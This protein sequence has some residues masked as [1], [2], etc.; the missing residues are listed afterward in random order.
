VCVTV[1]GRHTTTHYPIPTKLTDPVVP[2]PGRPR[3]ARRQRRVVGGDRLDVAP[4]RG[5][6]LVL[7]RGLLWLHRRGAARALC[8]RGEGGRAGRGRQARDTE[9]GGGGGVP[10]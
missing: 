1:N 5:G 3:R 6:R 10:R 9:K 7:L 8:A 2:R 4:R